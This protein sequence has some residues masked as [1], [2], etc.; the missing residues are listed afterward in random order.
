MR[1]LIAGGSGLIGRAVA[2]RWA[3]DGHQV[4]VLS[5]RPDGVRDLPTGVRAEA[6]T[7]G[8]S[9]RLAAQLDGADALVNLAGENVAGGR[10]TAR[11]KRELQASRV[12]LGRLLVAAWERTR[13]PPAV[14]LQASAVGYYGDPGDREVDETAAPGRDFLG[15]LCAAWEGSTA[16]VEV[17]G[18]RRVLLRTGIV[19]AREGGALPRL[20]P[21]FRA[22]VGGPVGSGAQWFPW[23]HV[24]DEVGAID[25]LL[26]RR[27]LAG[28]FNLTAPEP[29]RNR[30]FG[31]VLGRTLGRPSVLPLPALAL[32][33]ALGEM[34]DILL[35]GQRALPR[36]LLAAGYRFQ[37]PDLGG[38][39]ADLV[40]D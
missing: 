28:A 7:P 19:L 4:A 13:R 3:S 21:P 33:L 25:F 40:A 9:V 38:A 35:V 37:F 1:I 11:R 39:L 8:D 22:C 5:R 32:R 17:L 20:L 26:G 10:W 6:W 30:D 15:Q 2:A 16:G 24:V 31:K 27:D 34:A 14:L 29:V 36:R 23:I 12:D 18:T